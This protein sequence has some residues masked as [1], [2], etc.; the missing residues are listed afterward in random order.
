MT[1]KSVT[2]VALQKRWKKLSHI[3][4]TVERKFQGQII[5]VTGHT[6]YSKRKIENMV[7]AESGYLGDKDIWQQDQIMVIGKKGFDK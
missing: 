3:R 5:G 4:Y 7:I 2:T 6:P 1:T